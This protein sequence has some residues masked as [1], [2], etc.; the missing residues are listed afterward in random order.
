MARGKFAIFLALLVAALGL[1]TAP[2]KAGDPDE[3]SG[4][5]F[6]AIMRLPSPIGKWGHVACTPFG[7][8]LESRDGWVWAAVDSGT[9]VLI[10]SQITAGDPRQVGNESYFTAIRATQ[11]APDEAAASASM[12]NQGLIFDEPVSKAYRVDVI[13]VSGA[14]NTMYFFDFGTFGGGMVCPGDE[15]DPDTRFLIIERE[16]K[17][18]TP[19]I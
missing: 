9:K 4:T 5:P 7:H 15:C 13:S 12:F 1:G 2:V 16:P 11:L 8:V 18:R 3:C 10:P 19:G 6:D 14:I 17:T